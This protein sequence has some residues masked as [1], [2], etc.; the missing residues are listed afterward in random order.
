MLLII[1][2]ERICGVTKKILDARVSR[3]VGYGMKGTNKLLMPRLPTEML[4]TGF[5][6]SGLHT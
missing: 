2:L 5:L 4:S 3:E 6:M 1:K